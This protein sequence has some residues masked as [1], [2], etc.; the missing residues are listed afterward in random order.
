MPPIDEKLIHDVVLL[1]GQGMSRRAIARALHISRNTVRHILL[2]HGVVREQPHSALPQPTGIVRPSRLDPFRPRID[3]LLKNYPDITAQRVFEKLRDDGFV[4]GYDGVK[5]LVRGI[6]PKPKAKP[7]LETPKTG[8]GEMAECDWSEFFIPFT[9]AP[10]RKLQAFGYTLRYSTRKFF[11][12]HERN[13]L[14]ALMEGHRRVFQRFEG[15]AQ[16][17]KYDCQK[18]VVLR[19]EANQPIFNPRFIDFATFYEFQLVAARPRHPNDKPRV[20]RSFYELIRSF[21]NGRSFRDIDDLDSQLIHWMDTIC[22]LRPLKKK[23]RRPRLELFYEEKPLLRP[24]PSHPYDTARVLYKLCDIE[25]FIA[26]DGNRYSL[27]YEYVTD[28]L[29]VRIT[30]SELFVYK[31]DLSCIARHQLL[32]R[33]AG[34]DVVLPGHRPKSAEHGPNLDQL[35]TA[36][37]HLGGEAAFFLAKLEKRESKSAGYHA[38]KI[39]ALREGYATADLLKALSHALA[40][41]ALE[42]LAIERILIARSGRRRLDEYVAEA[43]AKKLERVVRNSCTEPRDLSEYDALPCRGSLLLPPGDI[44]C[45][46]PSEVPPD[47][48]Q[49]EKSKSDSSHTSNDSD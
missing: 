7:S 37:T 17:C 28:I 44:P 35:R 1:S 10:Q 12:F 27:P 46:S 16:K 34:E 43:S 41:G 6:R 14:F 38:R 21:L 2:K 40:Y 47:T 9:H 48:V 29:P 32:P 26:W 31:A 20:E 24:L 3:E 8:P 11:S 23:N 19:W 15:A 18:A 33:G 30:E 45:P 22:D 5:V 42:H 4:G 39:L 25:G 49:P 36:F 13:D